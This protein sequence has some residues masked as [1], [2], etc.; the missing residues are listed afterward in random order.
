[1]LCIIISVAAVQ[2][3]NEDRLEKIA[4]NRKLGKA[5]PPKGQGKRKAKKK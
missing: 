5:P 2:A 4:V 1:M 3:L